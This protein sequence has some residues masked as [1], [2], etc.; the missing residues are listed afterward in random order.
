MVGYFAVKP[1]RDPRRPEARSSSSAPPYESDDDRRRPGAACAPGGRRSLRRDGT[2]PGW[3]RR[4][5]SE[6]IRAR[7]PRN[8]TGFDEQPHLADQGNARDQ[9]PP[10]GLVTIVKP[11]C[12]RS[13][14]E[15]SY[16]TLRRFAMQELGWRKKQ[17]RRPGKERRLR[18]RDGRRV[19][20]VTAEAETR[21]ERPTAG[22]AHPQAANES[23]SSA[24][25][26][27]LPRVL[28]PFG[29]APQGIAGAQGGGAPAA[30]RRRIARPE[31]HER[32]DISSS[33]Q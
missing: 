14:P 33:G 31:L 1:R 28:R 21:S 30:F 26:L 13:G 19:R 4:G 23:T 25:S 11:L 20:S 29:Q 16:A 27:T 15:A 3:H 8:E 17:P 5:V 9:H 22:D 18:L 24:S 6:S 10:P 7:R 12:L 2:H 32:Q